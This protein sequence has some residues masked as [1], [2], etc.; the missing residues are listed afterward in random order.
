VPD[1]VAGL[2]DIVATINI[3]WSLFN[4]LP[5]LPL[6][7]GNMLLHAL[8]MAIAPNTADTVARGVSVVVALAAGA[9]GWFVLDSVFIPIVAALSIVQNIQRRAD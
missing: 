6:D 8:Q 9:A 5:M 2:L 7:G 4:L 1:R 3:F